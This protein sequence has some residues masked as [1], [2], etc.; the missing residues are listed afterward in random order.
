MIIN[1]KIEM[2]PKT[3]K[4]NLIFERF[5]KNLRWAYEKSAFY[6]NK[7]QAAQISINDI[8][9]LTDIK[10]LPLTTYTELSTVSTFDLLTGPLSLT[11]RLNKTL[12]GLYRGF[13][14]DDIARNIDIAIRPLASNNINKTTT[15]IICGNYSSQYLLDLHYAAEALGATVLPC[16]DLASAID[17]IDI[18]NANAILTTPDNLLAIAN[19]S[20]DKLPN[21]LIAL[22][23]DADIAK[24]STLN[25][26]LNKVIPRIYM[27]KYLG[28]AGIIFTCEHNHIHIQDDYLYPEIV[29]DR[30]V[31]T[32]LTLEAMPIIRLQTSIHAQIDT[33]QICSCGRTFPILLPTKI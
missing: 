25:K 10:K 18:F 20:I 15:L 24:L 33:A 29:D 31:L 11:L 27:S 19:K 13:T 7:Y 21:N 14:A 26:K 3:H 28:F 2:M 8:K 12:S 16:N 9:S 23:T 1:P 17:A 32:P 5:S 22:C 30:L 6:R 4:D